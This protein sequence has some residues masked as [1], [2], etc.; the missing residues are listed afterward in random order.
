MQPRVE[1]GKAT[2]W[3]SIALEQNVPTDAIAIAVCIGV[4]TAIL[5]DKKTK[6]TKNKKTKETKK[7][8]KKKKTK[9]KKT[10]NICLFALFACLFD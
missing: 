4:R 7:K 1:A 3:H 2:D 8:T 10:K 9:K 5:K 6:K